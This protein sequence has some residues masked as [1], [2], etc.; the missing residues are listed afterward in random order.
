MFSDSLSSCTSLEPTLPLQWATISSNAVVVQGIDWVLW[1]C[2][3]DIIHFPLIEKKSEKSEDWFLWN[4]RNLTNKE[5]LD[6]LFTIGR[7]G[8]ILCKTNLQ[9]S[10]KISLPLPVSCLHWL[11][12]CVDRQ[13][14]SGTGTFSSF[15]S[16]G[17]LGGIG[18]NDL[19]ATKWS[20]SSGKEI[21]VEKKNLQQ[22]A[23]TFATVL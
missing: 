9:Q 7:P 8:R 2:E 22:F 16:D 3:T 23:F 14:V 18:F 1:I 19:R 11:C 5:I 21:Y 10:K 17:W 20:K 13:V 4:L 6:W 15:L 12:C